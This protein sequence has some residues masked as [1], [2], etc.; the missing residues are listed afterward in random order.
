MFRVALLAS[1]IVVLGGASAPAQD[2]LAGRCFTV[3]L[4]H[5]SGEPIRPPLPGVFQ[6][7]SVPDPMMVDSAGGY[8]RIV[9][10]WTE[11]PNPR[12]PAGWRLIAGD[13]LELRW[14]LGVI[15]IRIVVP[16]SGDTLR[17]RAI[18]FGDEDNIPPQLPRHSRATVVVVSCAL[19][20]PGGQ[21]PSRR[22][23]H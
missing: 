12:W 2:S 1:V 22:P 23:S 16:A 19:L 14:S 20:W 11:T 10:D 13:S 21:A 5:W 18:T 6:L 8:H 17:G 7:D 3:R 4:G 15:G 9:P